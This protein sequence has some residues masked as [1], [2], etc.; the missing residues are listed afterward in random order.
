MLDKDHVAIEWSQNVGVIAPPLL[1]EQLMWSSRV[2]FLGINLQF[3]GEI[4]FGE[5]STVERFAD[6]LPAEVQGSGNEG[7]IVKITQGPTIFEDTPTLH[8]VR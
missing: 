8:Y 7:N 1:C 4:F 3:P 6:H 2:G 5:Q